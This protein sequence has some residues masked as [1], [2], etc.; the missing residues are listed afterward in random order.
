MFVFRRA[1]LPLYLTGLAAV[2]APVSIAACQVIMG[3]AIL[4]M[5]VTRARWRVPPIWLPL[6]VFFV[7]TLVSLAASG[8]PRQG[9]PQIKK[10]YVYSL[11]F[12]VVSNVRTI[13]QVRWIALGWA[14]AASLSAAWG[15]NQFYNRVEDAKESHQD[16]LHRLRRRSHHRFHE[17][18]DDFQRSHDDGA[19]GDRGA[20]FF[21][22]RSAF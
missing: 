10:F 4:A 3:L 22:Y 12:L 1:D 11:L 15:L 17:S 14:L 5:L 7:L 2:C 16:F 6:A 18:L 21:L 20:G 13:L 19:A 9:L 8:H